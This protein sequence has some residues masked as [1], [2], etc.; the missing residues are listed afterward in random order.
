MNDYLILVQYSGI[1]GLS[2]SSEIEVGPMDKRII[3][4]SHK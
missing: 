2:T 1:E 4:Y 3:F